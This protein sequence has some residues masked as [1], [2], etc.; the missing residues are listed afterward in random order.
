MGVKTMAKKTNGISAVYSS[1]TGTVVSACDVINILASAGKQLA[2]NA[3]TAAMVSR[4]NQETE[5]YEAFNELD[6]EKLAKVQ[7]LKALLRN[8]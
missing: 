2:Q 3:E 6:T 7:E 8:M 1:I 5:L 4:V